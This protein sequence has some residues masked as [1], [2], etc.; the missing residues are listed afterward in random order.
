[1][2]HV[3]LLV[4]VHHHAHA[5]AERLLDGLDPLPVHA[6]VGIVDLH[7]VVAAALARVEPRLLDDVLHAVLRPAAAAVGLDAVIGGPPEPEARLARGLAG[8]TPQR[9]VERGDGIRR[10]AHATDAAV[11]AEHL[12]PQ[13]F[14][15][16]WIFTQQQRLE[17]RLQVDLHRLRAAPA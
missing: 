11:G 8:Q 17:A 14:H 10:Q 2:Q 4:D 13:L 5:V 16:S 9:D 3:E 12:L 1:A 15:H 6:R 7:L